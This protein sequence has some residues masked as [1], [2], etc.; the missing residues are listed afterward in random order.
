MSTYFPT[1]FSTKGSEGHKLYMAGVTDMPKLN[2]KILSFKQEFMDL[3][4]RAYA[5]K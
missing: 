5:G 1:Y 4:K 2:D 3:V